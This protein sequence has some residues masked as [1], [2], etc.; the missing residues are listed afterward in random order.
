MTAVHRLWDRQRTE[1]GNLQLTEE[2]HQLQP[3]I[4]T[5]SI[6]FG[7]L[8]NDALTSA[9]LSFAELSINDADRRAGSKRPPSREREAALA[10]VQKDGRVITMLP[11]PLQEDK[12]LVLAAVRQSGSVLG[13]LDNILLREDKDVVLAAVEQD[14]YA[15]QY[16]GSLREDK[17][18]ALAAERQMDRT[19]GRSGL[20]LVARTALLQGPDWT[21]VGPLV[22]GMDRA[23]DD[24]AQPVCIFGMNAIAHIPATMPLTFAFSRACMTGKR[25]CGHHG[26][27]VC[28]GL[29]GRD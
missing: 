22:P 4:R 28:A 25:Q 19:T 13:L 12:E 7:D 27:G 18:V 10:A 2:D 5:K 6:A 24:G 29:T 17:E 9:E 1:R 15:I 3:L 16:A 11:R 20:V 8:R 26:R 21:Y 23:T 14:G